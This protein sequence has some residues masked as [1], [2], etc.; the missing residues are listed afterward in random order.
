MERVAIVGASSNRAKYANRA[1]RAYL[2]RGFTVHPVHPR[3]TEVEG[4]PTY[5]SVLEIPGPVDRVVLYVPPAV[6]LKVIEE[7]AQ[8]GVKE[9]WVSPGADSPEL[10]ARAAALG[11]EPTVAC[12]LLALGEP[13]ATE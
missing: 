1:V 2:A 6:G 12:S 11:L 4:L 8:K 13:P 5:R 10:L 7:V 3:E 9:L